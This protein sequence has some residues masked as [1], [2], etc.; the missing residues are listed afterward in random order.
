MQASGFN[1]TPFTI[2]Q[3]KKNQINMHTI[4]PA[5]VVQVM[6][7]EVHRLVHEHRRHHRRHHENTQ[8]NRHRNL[9]AKRLN[10]GPMAFDKLYRQ[11]QV[12]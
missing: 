4:N 8:T 7:L 1:N 12:S 9:H 10:I 3:S 6:Q 2:V 11:L 5:A